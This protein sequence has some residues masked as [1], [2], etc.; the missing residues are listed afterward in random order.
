MR[1]LKVLLITMVLASNMGLTLNCEECQELEID[2]NVAA[3]TVGVAFE[4]TIELLEACGCSGT[5][6]TEDAL[7]PGM[8][9]DGTLVSGTPTEAGSWDLEFAYVADSCDET[10]ESL[11]SQVTLTFDVN[12]APAP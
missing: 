10:I 12:P 8:A 9:F 6:S 3:A 1:V 4:H 2:T 7:P 5:F 11:L